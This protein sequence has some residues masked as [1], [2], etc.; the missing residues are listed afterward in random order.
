VAYAQISKNLTMGEGA[1]RVAVHRLR[2]RYGELL[3]SE[4]AHTVSSEEEVNEELH[5]LFQVLST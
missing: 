2:Q 4:I 1:V 5:Y 3:R